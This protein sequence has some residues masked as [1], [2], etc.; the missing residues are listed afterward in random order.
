[1]EEEYNVLNARG[2]RVSPLTV[3]KL[4][5]NAAAGNISIQ[6]GLKGPIT[7]TATA[8]A[9]AGNAVIDACRTIQYDDADIMIAGG[10]EAAL[11]ETRAGVLL[12]PAGPVA[13]Q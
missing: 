9:T 7:A 2:V 5:V 4:M 12:P 1:M 8:C 13:A 6:F 10:S 3:P 11:T